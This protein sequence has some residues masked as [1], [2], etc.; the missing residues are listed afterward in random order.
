MFL[1]LFFCFF[2]CLGLVVWLACFC[3]VFLFFIVRFGSCV[4]QVIVVCAIFHCVAVCRLVVVVVFVSVV[5]DVFVYYFRLY[6]PVLYV[7]SVCFLR[8]RVE[9][10]D[11]GVDL[12]CALFYLMHEYVVFLCECVVVFCVFHLVLKFSSVLI[13][14]VWFVFVYGW[15]CFVICSLYNVLCIVV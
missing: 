11:C 15:L 12:I 4:L 13:V 5:V 8:C 3:V 1:V 6:F 7:R 2:C 14:Y 9:S 10:L